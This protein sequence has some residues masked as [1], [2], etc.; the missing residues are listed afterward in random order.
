MFK[1]VS[2]TVIRFPWVFI[3]F[4]LLVSIGF[5][6][7]IPNAEIEPDLK[8]SIP[9]D[10]PCRVDT[11]KIEEIFG[12]TQ[13]IMAVIIADD[14]LNPETLTRAKELSKRMGRL[15]Q[16]DRVLSLFELKDIRAEGG[17]MLVDPAVKRIPHTAEEREKLRES[18]RDNDLV[19]G[20]VVARDFTATAIIGMLRLGISDNE[21]LSAVEKMIAEVPGPEPVE[22]GGIPY[23]RNIV[24]K[25]MREDMRF[26]MSFG[27]LIMLVFL[28][29]CFR[30]LRGVVLPFLVVVMSI[31]LSMGIIPLMGWKIH[32]LS[33]LLP[34]ML[35]AVA[36]DYGI[37]LIA[38]Y[39]EDNYPGNTLTPK[40]L[41]KRMIQDLGKPVLFAAVTT[42]AGML[43]LMSHI[44]IP[45]KQ[46]GVLAAVGI[47]FAFLASVTF[48]PAVIAL[49][50]KP[51]PIVDLKKESGK[52]PA[53]D[54][55]LLFMARF[56]S[57]RPK[58]IVVFAFAGV[59]LVSTG[60]YFLQ[61][62]TNMVNF[63]SSDAP[64][65]RS[66][67]MVN[68]YFGGNDSIS[69][70]A[71]GDIKDPDILRHINDLERGLESQPNVGTTSSLARVIRRMNKVMNDG[72][73][74]YDR[75]PDTRD[76]I[77]QYLLLYSMSGD[78]DD[79][80]RLVD[81]PY[82]HAQITA[83]INTTSMKGI[84]EVVRYAKD[85][86]KNDP[87]SPF[88]IIGGHGVMFT[89]MIQIIVNGQIKSLLASLLVTTIL[90]SLLFQSSVAGLL[91]FLIL[92]L[93][94]AV[95]FGLMGYLGINLDV[96]TS[97]LSA[98][99]IGVGVDYTIHYF[100]RY[101]IE[102][103]AGKEPADAV[104]STLTTV[105][106]GIIFNA[107]SV[108]VGFA[109]LFASAFLPVKFFGF[110]VVVSISACLMGALVLL[111]AISLVFRPKFL[112]P[113]SE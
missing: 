73:P 54:R 105:G 24:G 110:L 38:K 10:H 34:V 81:F 19:Y 112:E 61:V 86:V 111:P 16:V 32:V 56:V 80:D 91:A 93:A 77:A 90:M 18:L 69:V 101:R 41:A 99:M 102:R 75:I 52:R 100:W 107:L 40:D 20:N 42:M 6:S 30:Q 74:A 49:I 14:V 98:I 37:H 103:S 33:V 83:R 23:V 7:F 82:R 8:R 70:V 72:D 15:S 12:G 97:M 58:L 60:I 79:F 39:Q 45:A 89:D 47:A 1:R 113:K 4:F 36:N 104:V 5:G 66:A 67:N 53:L 59:A 29:I 51:K 64:V 9:K 25:D 28:Y 26:F 62:E 35:I 44:M 106:R 78:P 13:M 71:E 48:I 57:K 21:V 11:D 92:G 46:L 17:E 108:V 3:A 27:L 50:P 2:E 84:S 76:A 96:A 94:M 95:L 85:Y 43:C 55:S 88:N 109:I 87:N 63:Y 31:A 68:K 65:F 22:L